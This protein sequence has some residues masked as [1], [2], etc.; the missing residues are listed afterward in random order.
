[1]WHNASETNQNEN[2]YVYDF[3]NY[4]DTIMA[5]DVSDARE[6]DNAGFVPEPAQEFMRAR[7]EEWRSE[8]SLS[9]NKKKGKSQKSV[10]GWT[11]WVST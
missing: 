9:V 6:Y 2:M 1:M 3:D 11:S 10:L 4:E 5:A 8:E 7:Q